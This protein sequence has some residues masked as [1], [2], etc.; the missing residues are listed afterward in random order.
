MY[1]QA[2]A[3][4]GDTVVKRLPTKEH[5]RPLLLGPEL[6]KAV[7]EYVEPTKAVGGVVN[8]AIVMAAAVGIVLARDLTKLSSHTHH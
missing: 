5:E 8:T 3:R 4:D 2:I 7:Q 1:L 6:D